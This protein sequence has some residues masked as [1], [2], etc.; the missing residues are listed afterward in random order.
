MSSAGEQALPHLRGEGHSKGLERHH[1][2]RRAKRSQ[3]GRLRDQ[4]LNLLVRTHCIQRLAKV[5]HG[6]KLVGR[7][8]AA[9]ILAG[10]YTA[11]IQKYNLLICRR[12]FREVA[13]S[14][15]FKKNM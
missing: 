9:H 5:L 6:A 8:Q 7:G 15:G 2:E 1:H 14:L 10:D 13:E 11:V 3:L 12:C 4:R